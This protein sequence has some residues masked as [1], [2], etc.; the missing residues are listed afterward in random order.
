MGSTRL[1][2]PIAFGRGVMLV[3]VIATISG[4]GCA[5]APPVPSRGERVRAVCPVVEEHD[6]YFPEESIVVADA[7][8]DLERRLF[9]SNYL[10]EAGVPSLSCGDVPDTYRLT[11]IGG[12]NEVTLVVTVNRSS[13]TAVQFLPFNVADRTVSHRTSKPISAADFRTI[14]TCVESAA[15]WTSD[16]Y[17]VFESE[18]RS[19]TFEGRR[20]DSY[21]ALTRTHPELNLANV[22]K[23][24]VELSGM[25]VPANMTTRDK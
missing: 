3:A 11:W 24:L 25:A 12:Y 5:E 4:T 2:I 9:L 6:Y 14:S 17:R 21:R 7:D 15:F 8:R 18:G 13:A 22:A 1:S 23:L 19:W 16:A 20:G 10:R